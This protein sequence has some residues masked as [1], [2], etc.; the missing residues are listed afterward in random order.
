MSE[1]IHLT[2][3]GEQIQTQVDPD[4]SLLTFL[5]EELGLTGAKDGCSEGTCGACTVIV[6]GQARR[7]C[8]LK[9]KRMAGRCVETVEALADGDRLH[10]LQYTL[11]RE[12]AIQCGFCTP[13]VVM[14]GKALLDANSDPTDAEIKKALRHNICRC[15]GYRPIIDAV[16][17]AASLLREGV[18]SLPAGELYPAEDQVVGRGVARVDGVDKVTGRLRYSAD[19]H[20]AGMLHAKVLRAA[21]PHARLL[22][23][24]T[25][26]AEQAPGVVAVLTAQDMPG[27][28]RFG[29]IR[30]DQPVFAEDRVR[31]LGET[32]AAVYAESEALAEAALA[33]IRVEYE[34]LPAIENPQQALAKGAVAIHDD[35]NLTCHIPIRKG[36]VEAGFAQADVIVEGEY[37]TPTVE[38]GYLEPEAGLAVPGDGARVAVYVGSQSSIHDQEDIAA[39][40]DLPLEEVRVVHMPM[41]GGFGGKEDITVQIIAALGALKT[42]RP[43]KFVWTR[44]ESLLAS[45][46]RH[47]EWLRYRTGATR[48]GRLV[49]AEV[50]IYGDGGAYASATDAV[51]F[52]SASFACGP[53]RIPHVK[54]DVYGAFT[55]NPPG[56]AFRG[57]GNPQVTFAAEI[58]MDRL[59]EALGLDPVEFRLKNILGPG[60]VTITGH[61]LQYSVGARATLEAVRDALAESG[62]PEPPPGKRI[63]VGYA[64]S[65]KNVGLGSGM[66]DGAGARLT[67]QPD[68]TVLLREGA[69]D[70]GQG[71]D[72]AMVQIA[73]QTLGVAYNRIRLHVGDTAQDPSGWMTTASRQTFVSGNAV[74]QAAKGLRA[75][76]C[77]AV[78]RAF[79][80]PP[81]AV[82]LANGAFYL[83]DGRERLR[84]LDEFAAEAAAEGQTFEHEAFYVAPRTYPV[85]EHADPAPVP[86]QNPD[87]T[88]LHFAYSF[89]A[90]A[91]IVAVDEGTNEVELLKVISASDVGEPINPQGIRGQIE[92]GIVMGMG[93]GLSEE[94]RLEAGRPVTE[95]FARLGLPTI[96]QVPEMVAISVSN[97]HP[98]G[99]YG[100]KGMGELP[101]SPT[102]AAIANAV[103]AAVGARVRSLPITP[104]KI[105]AARGT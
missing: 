16:R 20:A 74:Y 59:A 2:V 97:P 101:M 44:R 17:E 73:A 27:R 69:M 71:S 85:P 4:L 55:N 5:R 8:T 12:G 88:S 29:I 7:A 94:F 30:K 28:N 62:L 1:L 18:T 26:A 38:H 99:P 98:E 63:G 79:D 76:L 45:G 6:D 3:N 67:L 89:A 34:P 104:A 41:G 100:A 56:C 105:A 102:A 50:E 43:V 35:G 39:A 91:A 13:G 11:V 75:E 64:A 103:Y 96:G 92:G 40:L 90:Q 22:R 24:D 46:K 14:A 93:Y 61:V 60:D 72:T 33:L 84:T 19:L 95:R 42:G 77:A 51:L 25:S 32:I 9:M 21:H 66:E 68:G 65:Y 80:L 53:Y 83:A 86:G 31:Y 49:A 58:Q 57:F 87:E 52:R 47:A 54:V 82:T 23:I 81:E 36:D 48:D 70:M 15:T 10:P 37:F 78:A